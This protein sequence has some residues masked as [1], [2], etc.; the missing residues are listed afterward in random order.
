MP[1]FDFHCS[2]CKHVFEANVAFGS[3]KLPTCP[4]CGN[5]NVEKMLSVP[6]IMFK[7]SG[8]YKNDSQKAPVVPPAPSEGTAKKPE[9]P[10]TKQP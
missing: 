8:F 2:A 4:H 6:G 1:T 3:K 5:K 10:P 7:G 9:P